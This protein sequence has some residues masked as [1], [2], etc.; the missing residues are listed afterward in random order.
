MSARRVAGRGG[1]SRG[2]RC[3]SPAFVCP[4]P[5]VTHTAYSAR[6]RWG[7][8]RRGGE[9]GAGGVTKKQVMWNSL[10]RLSV[11]ALARPGRAM[12]SGYVVERQGVE[13]GGGE[14]ATWCALRYLE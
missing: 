13:G 11:S 7:P 1:A 5:L 12:R 2:G 4:A 3:I 8:P 9:G 14:A 10:S 6:G